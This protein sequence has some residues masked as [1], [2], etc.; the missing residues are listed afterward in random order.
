[1][2]PQLFTLIVA[3]RFGFDTEILAA[4]LACVTII[5]FGTLPIVHC[6]LA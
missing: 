6:I 3:D 1:M 2:P 4:A 5:S